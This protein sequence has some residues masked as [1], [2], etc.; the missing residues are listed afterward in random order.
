MNIIEHFLEL[1]NKNRRKKKSPEKNQKK[2]CRQ[3]HNYH[4]DSPSIIN[5]RKKIKNTRYTKI[6]IEDSLGK[7]SQK[8]TID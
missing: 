5:Q 4:V 8:N 2:M 1:L 7:I 3:E 6:K